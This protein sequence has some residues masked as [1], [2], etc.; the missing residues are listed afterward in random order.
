MGVKPL[1]G[2]GGADG[3]NGGG[4]GAAADELDV[5]LVDFGLAKDVRA[6][7]GGE[8]LEDLGEAGGALLAPT[9]TIAG[10]PSFIAPEV[11]FEVAATRL[12]TPRPRSMHFLS[13]ML[14]VH[15]RCI[16]LSRLTP[17]R[18]RARRW[19]RWIRDAS[20]S[21]TAASSS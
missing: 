15:R 7:A 14:K 17:R 12:H 16:S 2:N 6:A 5:V 20:V 19:R 13:S 8:G 18:S 1:G 21:A 11:V 9:R 4:G 3:G 10:T